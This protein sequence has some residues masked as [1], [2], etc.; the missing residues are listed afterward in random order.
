M[1]L[2]VI[3]MEYR[4]RDPCRLYRL[5]NVV[6]SYHIRAAENARRMIGYRSGHSP[7]CGG[8]AAGHAYYPLAGGS[9]EHGIIFKAD[10]SEISGYREILRVALAEAHPGVKTNAFPSDSVGNAFSSSFAEECGQLAAYVGIFVKLNVV[11]D[12]AAGLVK[13]SV[14]SHKRLAEAGHIVYDMR[15]K[16][17]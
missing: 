17:H 5:G 12:Y 1:Q 9:R 7:V 8:I 11:H 6:D 13:C 4:V 15:S 14:F 16:L 10:I 2:F 3:G